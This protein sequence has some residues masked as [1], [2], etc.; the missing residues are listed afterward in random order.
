MYQLQYQGTPVIESVKN[1]KTFGSISNSCNC[2]FKSRRE[3]GFENCGK[4]NGCMGAIGLAA[5]CN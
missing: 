4:E 5:R 2:E 1:N 3:I